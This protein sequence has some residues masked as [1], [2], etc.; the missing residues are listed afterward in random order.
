[1]T[2]IASAMQ[3]T[4]KRIGVFMV[5]V[6]AARSAGQRKTVVAEFPHDINEIPRTD[7]LNPR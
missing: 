3:P 5:R 2:A 6:S 4:K 7:L 1:M